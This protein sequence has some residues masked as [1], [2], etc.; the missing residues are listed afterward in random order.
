MVIISLVQCGHSAF[1]VCFQV[2]MTM[3]WEK[4]IRAQVNRESL[5]TRRRWLFLL[6]SFLIVILYLFFGIELDSALHLE[7]SKIQLCVIHDVNPYV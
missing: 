4:P 7:T 1:S 6:L 3:A 5:Q 2:I